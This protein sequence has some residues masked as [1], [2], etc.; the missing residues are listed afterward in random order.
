M[1]PDLALLQVKES[2]LDA[3]GAEAFAQTLVESKALSKYRIR[4]FSAGS[5]RG[6]DSQKLYNEV[7]K[8]FRAM[9]PT[10]II[11]ISR[12]K[13]PYEKVD[14]IAACGLW[15]G[16]SL[17]GLII[18][19]A[20]DVPRVALELE[21]L[22]RYAESW[23]ETLPFGVQIDDLND[24]VDAAIAAADSS[25]KSGRASELSRLAEKSAVAG[26]SIACEAGNRTELTQKRSR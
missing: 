15:V 26:A 8:A 22:V 1:E 9:A 12:A 4:L 11:D 19:T 6:H 10:R 23:G 3:Y 13:Q 17:H 2:V 7:L 21:K 16:T 18:S 25:A 14:E 24:A 5:A 20:Y